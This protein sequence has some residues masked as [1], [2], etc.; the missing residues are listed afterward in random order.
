MK[1]L[2]IK[3]L[4]ENY[5]QEQLIQAEEALLKEQPL[6]ITVEGSDDSERLSYI[7]AAIF[8]LEKIKQE[9]MEFKTA[10]RS[11]TERV[12]ESIR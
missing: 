7:L 11:Y 1:I 3:A 4:V 5:T 12:R 2:V 9:K 10:L 6:P 8:V